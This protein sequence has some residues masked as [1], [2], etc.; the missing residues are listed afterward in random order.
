MNISLF[1]SRKSKNLAFSCDRDNNAGCWIVEMTDLQSCQWSNLS[2][3]SACRWMPLLIQRPN[4]CRRTTGLY[5]GRRRRTKIVTLNKTMPVPGNI[6]VRTIFGP[7]PNLAFPG[8]ETQTLPW[9]A[10]WPNPNIAAHWDDKV[11][12]SPQSDGNFQMVTTV[13]YTCTLRVWSLRC[14]ISTKL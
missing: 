3:C 7:P 4:S 6:R 10:Y 14:A 11:S 13:T 12:D 8:L 2:R 9:L 5:G 1:S